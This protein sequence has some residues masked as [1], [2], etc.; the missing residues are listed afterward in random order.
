MKHSSN[1]TIPADSLD[2]D[3]IFF[4]KFNSKVF[5]T[6]FLTRFC[7]HIICI[8]GKGQFQLGGHTYHFEKNDFVIWVPG[9]KV[10]DILLS[11]DFK[12]YI[13]LLSRKFLEEMRP[14]SKLS[15]EGYLYTLKCP[16]VPLTDDEMRVFE[17]NYRILGERITDTN[18]VHYRDIITCLAHIMIYDNFNAYSN[19]INKK[20]FSEQSSGIFERFLILMQDYCSTNR[21]VSFY[22]DKLHISPKY[23]SAVCKN[24]S[25]KTAS[26]WINEYA[27]QH[28]RTLLKNDKL[29]LKDIS[30]Q[31]NFNN[32]SFFA[33]YVKRLLG[34][35]PSK[36]REEQKKEESAN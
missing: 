5:S 26:D 23:L 16:V 18:N 6:E 11:P 31:M 30:N 27:I 25:G 28:A 8:E 19:L 15:V 3:V 24:A 21:E 32:Q 14:S 36:Y 22:S 29:T 17:W 7:T 34:V 20:T 13:L 1:T 35:S 33:R 4:E 9:T 10:T 2:E 12:S